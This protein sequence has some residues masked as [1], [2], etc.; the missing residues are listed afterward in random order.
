MTKAE[1]ITQIAEKSELSKKDSEKALAA[2]GSSFT[3]MTFITS[4]ILGLCMGSGADE[5]LSEYPRCKDVS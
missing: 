2:V 1:L 4:I 5:V 3:L